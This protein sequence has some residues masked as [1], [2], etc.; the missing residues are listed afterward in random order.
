MK[1]PFCSYCGSSNLI[2]YT[3][4]LEKIIDNKALVIPNIPATKCNDCNEIHYDNEADKYIDK[5]IAIF[6]AEG[7]ENRSKEV[8]K[9]KGI[10]QEELGNMIGVT[11]QRI[12]QI[13]KDDNL[14]V[15]TMYKIANAIDEPVQNVFSFNRITQ[16][17]SKFYIENE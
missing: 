6:K 16:K 15:K 10:T 4:T 5:Q 8:V 17:D 12:N 2:S 11:K 3:D 14:D 9:S 1:I 7:F 13:F